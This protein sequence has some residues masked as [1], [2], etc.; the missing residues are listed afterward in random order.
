MEHTFIILF[1]IATIVAIAVS[2]TRVPY[3]VALVVVGLIVGSLNLVDPPKL[4]K[5]LLFSLFLPGLIF[6]AAYNIHMRELQQS[7]R[8]VTALAAPG[9]IAAIGLTG[10]LIAWSLRAFGLQ[11]DFTWREG[12]VFA[13][14]VSATDPIA[15]V[16]LFRKLG[17][18]PRLT[19]LV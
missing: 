3:T 2:R 17:V 5:E 18:T 16:S 6:E 19:T 4:T 12:L 7:W 1:S 10:V 8:T 9:V 15:V 13:A 11:P 14:L